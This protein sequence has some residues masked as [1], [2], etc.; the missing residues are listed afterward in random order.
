MVRLF[1]ASAIQRVPE[2][3]AW[4]LIEALADH[5]EDADD[6]NLPLLLW[7][8]LAQRLPRN[9]E[10]AFALANSS[11]LPQLADYICWYAATLEGQGRCF[12]RGKLVRS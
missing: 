8:S 5:P 2:T 3:I 7:Q 9:L 11:L 6:R 10:R 4:Q 1:L 12:I